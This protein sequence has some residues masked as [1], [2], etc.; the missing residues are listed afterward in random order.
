M[1]YSLQNDEF[2]MFIAND[3]DYPAR[4]ELLVA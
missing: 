3:K 2:W 4:I 1:E